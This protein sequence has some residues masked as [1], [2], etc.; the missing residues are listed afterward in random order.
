MFSDQ[1]V[2]HPVSSIKP[3]KIADSYSSFGH[4]L[5]FSGLF[6]HSRSSFVKTGPMKA[7]LSRLF[8]RPA[9]YGYYITGLLRR[10]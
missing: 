3:R 4:I 8:I 6:L 7:L 10:V 9:F 2:I 5:L 1:R